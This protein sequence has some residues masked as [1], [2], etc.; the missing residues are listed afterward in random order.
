[1][2]MKFKPLLL[3]LACS[4]PFSATPAFANLDFDL[5]TAAGSGD[6][7]TVKT[8]VEHGAD[9]NERDSEGYT[10]LIWAAQHGNARVVEYLIDHGANLNPLDNGA[11]TPLMWAVQEGQ[12][13]SVALLLERGANP[14]ARGAN[15]RTALD[16]ATYSRDGRVRDLL[17]GY[18]MGVTKPRGASAQRLPNMP[19]TAMGMNAR[20]VSMGSG[21]VSMGNAPQMAMG[22]PP[23]MAM[24]PVT[25]RPLVEPDIV[26]KAFALK[27]LAESAVQAGQAVDTYVKATSSSFSLSALSDPDLGLG[28]ELTMMYANL[29]RT[30][31][32][33]GCR[34]DWQK[35][36]SAWNNRAD[37]RFAKY[38]V[39][40]DQ[41]LK[42][43]GL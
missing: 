33:V 11:Y 37:S 18:A 38:V 20:P 42:G 4:A 2:R 31:S 5:A 24:A 30:Q 12:F 36:R 23:Q 16:L 8:L 14:N 27:K 43:A 15:G 40:V 9:L 3:A 25:D 1:M 10:P 7:Y 32:L 17:Y 39:D 28:K 22:N 21:P 6:Y 13:S 19:T 29:A 41:A 26:T 34:Q 35:V